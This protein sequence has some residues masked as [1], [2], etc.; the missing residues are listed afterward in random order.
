MGNFINK[1]FKKI[2]CKVII[3]GLDNAGKTSFLNS[4]IKRENY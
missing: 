4:L 2:K 1:L 3:L